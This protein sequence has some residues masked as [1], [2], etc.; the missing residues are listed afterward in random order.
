M[1]DI[2]GGSTEFVVG[3]AGEMDFHVSTQAGVVRQT[4]R[5]LHTDPPTADELRALSADVRGIVEDGV[6]P[7]IRARVQAGVAV[8]GTAT[9]C[10]AID[11]E[12][13]P[14][15]PGRVHGYALSR[16]RLEALLDRLAALPLDERASR[17]AACTPT[18]RPTIVAGV[19]I[20][21]RGDGAFGLDR[22]RGLRARHPARSRAGPPHTAK[23]AVFSTA[24]RAW[25]DVRLCRPVTHA[26]TR[27]CREGVRAL[28]PRPRNRS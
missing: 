25:T 16:D 7:E 9:Q 28:L 26:D 24:D 6:A 21:L 14:Y 18:A 8:A 2:G 10:A 5:H 17:S 19:A 27:R 20:L 22:G 12:L 23:S 3:H 4:E 15:D 13:E 11:Q 1:I